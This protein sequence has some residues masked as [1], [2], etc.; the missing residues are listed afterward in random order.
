[1]EYLLTLKYKIPPQDCEEEPLMRR[2]AA[3]GCKDALIVVG[4]RGRLMLSFKRHDECG[5]QALLS[6]LHHVRKAIPGARL[7]EAA[8]DMVG[9]TDVAAMVGVSRQN[10]RKL[11]LTHP[12]SFPS[13]IHEGNS[14]SVWHLWDVLCWMRGR[15][16]YRIDEAVLELAKVAKTVN[17]VRECRHLEDRKR[18]EFVKLVA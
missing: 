3:V 1:M 11:M 2:L 14:S 5:E 17:L 4:L 16:G 8:P 15:G 12:M 13:P 18:E 10:M 6:A 7:I 9:L